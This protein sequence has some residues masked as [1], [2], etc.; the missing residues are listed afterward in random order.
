MNI[1]EVGKFFYILWSIVAISTGIIALFF[2]KWSMEFMERGFL[3]WYKKTNF[4]L[5]K[6]QAEGLTKPYMNILSIF[7]G[8]VFLVLGI[9]TLF[10]NIGITHTHIMGKW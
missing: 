9:L 2:R 4:H 7:L 3:L 6:L 5:F 10:E 8:I 1:D